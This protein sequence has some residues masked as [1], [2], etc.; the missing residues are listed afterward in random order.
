MACKLPMY[1]DFEEEELKYM[2]QSQWISE[3]GLDSTYRNLVIPSGAQ[4]YAENADV[5]LIPS[6]FIIS[7]D[8]DSYYDR[9]R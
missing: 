9:Y 2:T 7:E 8:Y 6:E 5:Q 3:D 1:T 4:I